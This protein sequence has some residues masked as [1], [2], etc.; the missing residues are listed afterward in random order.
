MTALLGAGATRELL[1]RHGVAP[2][3]ELGQ[4]F[5]VDPNTIR[6]IVAVSGCR[7]GD[8]VVEVGAGVGALTLALAEVAARVVAIEFD[9]RLLPALR[10]VVGSRPNVEIVEADALRVDLGSFGATA[11]VANLPYNIAVPVVLRALEGAPELGS[12]TVMTQREVGERL[13][14]SSGSRAYGQVSVLVRY[15]ARAAVAARVSRNA[16]YPVPGVDSVIVRIERAPRPAGVGYRR[17]RELV[18]T[19]FEQRRKTLRNALTPLYGSPRAAE[20]MLAA[21]GVDPRAR[22][23]Q[24]PPEGWFELA[25]DG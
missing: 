11:M 21:A 23:E 25:R 24:V 4:N 15:W 8:A 17:L 10:E 2:R 14:A 18:R 22:A 12:L 3:R 7:S 19:G 9:R 13:A 1:S 20:R 6:K 16:F 5:V